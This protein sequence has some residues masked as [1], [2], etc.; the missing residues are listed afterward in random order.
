MLCYQETERR[1]ETLCI[2]NCPDKR[3]AISLTHSLNTPKTC[4]WQGHVYLRFLATWMFARPLNLNTSQ[5]NTGRAVPGV[6]SHGISAFLPCTRR[7]GSTRRHRFTRSCQPNGSFLWILFCFA[8]CPSCVC[9]VISN[10]VRFSFH[11]THFVNFGCLHPCA[12]H[13]FRDLDTPCQITLERAHEFV[14]VRM[15]GCGT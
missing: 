3:T 14:H 12:A 11:S 13:S 4:S 1:E 5:W 6:E 2:C 8:G 10:P 7:M 9:S 15:C